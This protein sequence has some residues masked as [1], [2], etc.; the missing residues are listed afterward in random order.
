[1]VSSSSPDS[2]DLTSSSD[3]FDSSGSSDPLDS[4]ESSTANAR[5]LTDGGNP[6]SDSAADPQHDTATEVREGTRDALY[7]TI[8]T[9]ALL[10]F[11]LLFIGVGTRG[12][13]TADSTASGALGVGIGLFGVVLAA[14]AFDVVPLSRE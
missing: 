2:V 11:S 13:V 7:D 8:G 9:V 10:G 5:L 12:L 1:M 3:P 6:T 14:I 4:S